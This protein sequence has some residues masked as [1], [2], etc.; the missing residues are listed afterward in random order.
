MRAALARELR[1]IDCVELGERPDPVPGAGAVLPLAPV[2]LALAQ[3]AG[4][5]TRGKIVLQVG[6]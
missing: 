6:Q 1:G 4:R 5:R 3:V 2:G